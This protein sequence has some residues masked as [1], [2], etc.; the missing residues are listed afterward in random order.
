MADILEV[1]PE[2]STQTELNAYMGT[3]HAALDKT[4]DAEKGFE[5]T[6]L[7]VG[8]DKAWQTHATMQTGHIANMGASL[9]RAR[10]DNGM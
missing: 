9:E 5:D 8:L 3:H 10:I 6:K 4:V 7:Q 1:K 2:G